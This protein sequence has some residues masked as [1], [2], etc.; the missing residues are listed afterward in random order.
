MIGVPHTRDIRVKRLER[1]IANFVD[2]IG[3]GDGSAAVLS[4]LKIAEARKAALEADARSRLDAVARQIGLSL[5]DP[6][7]LMPLIGGR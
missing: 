5:P 2:T 6:A 7:L 1:K 3:E 4:A